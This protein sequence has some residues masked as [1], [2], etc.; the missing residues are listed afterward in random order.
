MPT[1]QAQ[2]R[3]R[4]AL[5]ELHEALVEYRDTT[6]SRHAKRLIQGSIEMVKG[7]E[8]VFIQLTKPKEKKQ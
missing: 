2:E 4:A 8:G 5:A 6:R 1:W 3:V 7:V